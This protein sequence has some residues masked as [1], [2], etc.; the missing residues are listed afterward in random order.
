MS[1]QLTRT[2]RNSR[3]VFL[4]LGPRVR[5]TPGANLNSEI[6]KGKLVNGFPFSFVD[7]SNVSKMCPRKKIRGS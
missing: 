3:V 7:S 5:V 6:T 1:H 2:D 4:I